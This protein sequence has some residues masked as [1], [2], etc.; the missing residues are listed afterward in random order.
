MTEIERGRWYPAPAPSLDGETDD[1]Y[2]NRL[3][4]IGD[5]D[6]R[7]YDH[8]RNRQCSI[9]YHTECSD[10]AGERCKCPCHTDPGPPAD[11]VLNEEAA[12]V[13]AELYSLPATTARRVLFETA[14]ALR[15]QE[16]TDPA[17]LAAFLGRVYGST[18]TESF[19]CDAQGL[20]VRYAPDKSFG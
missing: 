2:T 13:L 7:P 11:A 3:L 14:N 15:T 16:A 10:P 19:A 18:I 12:E 8:P 6:R 5:P 4:G 9:G 20:H 17:E 1:T